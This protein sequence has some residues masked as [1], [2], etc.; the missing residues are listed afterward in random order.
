[1][2]TLIHGEDIASSR[3]AFG[4]LKQ[5]Y[6]SSELV[7]FNGKTVQLTEF[8][9]AFDAPSLLGDKRIVVIERFFS[10]PFTKEKTQILAF[11]TKNRSSSDIIFWDEKEVEKT[12]KNKLGIPLNELRYQPPMIIFKFLDGIGLLKGVDLL[13]QF[14]EIIKTKD[15]QLVYSLLLRHIRNLIIAKDLGQRGFGAMPPWQSGKFIRQAHFFELD[16]IIRL[17][18]QLLSIDYQIKKGQT[19]LPLSTLLD[20]FFVSM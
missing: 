10:G 20:F 11:L 6:S 2:I 1:M 19:P 15:A 18:R 14:H 8:V 5:T 3:K 12:S 16:D 4:D 7:T 13:K 9:T 17:Y